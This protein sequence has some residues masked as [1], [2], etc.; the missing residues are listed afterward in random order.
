MTLARATT[1]R[2]RVSVFAA[3]VALAQLAVASAARA[4]PGQ[5]VLLGNTQQRESADVY[6]PSIRE[7]IEAVEPRSKVQAKQYRQRY[8]RGGRQPKSH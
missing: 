8:R 6:R 1:N 3:C 4:E 7:G 5:D 2:R